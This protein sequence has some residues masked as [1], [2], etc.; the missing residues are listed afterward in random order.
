MESIILYIPSSVKIRNEIFDGFGKKELMQSM[1]GSFFGVI[2]AGLV[3]LISHNIAFT[4]VAV[5]T[6]I[7]GSVMMCTK[8]QYNQSV[9][10][11]IGNMIRYAREQQI[12]PYRALNEWAE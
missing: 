6:G 4:V 11:Q 1:A 7:F 9:V 12:Y 3:W 8:D 5:L 10:D 2:S